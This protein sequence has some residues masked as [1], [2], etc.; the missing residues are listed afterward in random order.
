MVSRNKHRLRGARQGRQKIWTIE[1]GVAASSMGSG[2]G[3][4]AKK[5]RNPAKRNKKPSKGEARRCCV[6]PW[7]AAA[8]AAPHLRGAVCQELVVLLR[9][10][11][12][13]VGLQVKMLLPAHPRLPLQH[14]VGGGRRQRGL[15]VTALH[16]VPPPLKV[17]P[18]PNGGVDV[19]HGGEVLVLHL[20]CQ[21]PGARRR[22][23]VCCHH[24]DGLTHARHHLLRQSQFA[25]GETHGLPREA[26]R[27]PLSKARVR[28]S[29]PSALCASR[30][31][32]R[33]SP[34]QRAPRR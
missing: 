2:S 19:E 13:G 6:A 16:A 14:A 23:A 12:V 33:R 30:A 21:R 17:R 25:R 1:A 27:R 31:R 9:K 5:G 32:V 8:P 26:R 24:S 20:Y 34:W 10:N 7:A 15:H 22:L 29:L 4:K 11:H 3:G 18:R 28:R